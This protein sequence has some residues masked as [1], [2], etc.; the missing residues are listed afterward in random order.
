MKKLI[1]LMTFLFSFNAS[2]LALFFDQFA[3]NTTIA[4]PGSIVTK[5]FEFRHFTYAD[6]IVV[7]TAGSGTLTV[8]FAADRLGASI[9]D[10]ANTI[11][12]DTTA[13]SSLIGSGI[14]KHFIRLKITCA[15]APCT[16]SGWF[17]AKG[18]I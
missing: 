4:A 16:F 6:F 15:V 1:I 5:F 12:F 14:S 10:D 11:P 9:I 7:A 8:Q 18:F 17:T 2:A 3:V 13:P